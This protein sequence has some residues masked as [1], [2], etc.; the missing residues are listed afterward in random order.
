MQPAQPD[1][2]SADVQ[3]AVIYPWGIRVQRAVQPLARAAA[4][5]QGLGQGLGLA[6]KSAWVATSHSLFLPFD[7]LA[8][9]EYNVHHGL[10]DK[11]VAVANIVEVNDARL[12]T[13]PGAQAV[14]FDASALLHKHRGAPWLVSGGF[15]LGGQE[16]L[17]CEAVWGLIVC[18]AELGT[19]GR[20][21]PPM[22]ATAHAV[23]QWL[24]GHEAS[25]HSSPACGHIAALMDV[26]HTGLR[27]RATHLQACPSV[28]AQGRGHLV[29][30]LAGE[31][32]FP[33]AG[34]WRVASSAPTSTSTP[35]LACAAG[36][37]P[38]APSL[39]VFQ[40]R[41][42]RLWQVAAGLG[43][44]MSPAPSGADE[45]AQPSHF[46][47]LEFVQNTGLQQIRFPHPRLESLVMNSR[48]EYGR[49][50]FA[51]RATLGWDD[52]V[53]MHPPAGAH[54]QGFGTPSSSTG[55]IPLG[56]KDKFSL[57]VD[58]WHFKKTWGLN[59]H[60]RAALLRW[61]PASLSACPVEGRVDFGF[62]NSTWTSQQ[63]PL[64]FELQSGDAR[65]LVLTAEGLCAGTSV[66][67][68]L[69]GPAWHWGEAY[70]DVQDLV[71]QLLE[72]LPSHRRMGIDAADGPLRLHDTFAMPVVH[73]GFG[74]ARH[75]QASLGS[76]RAR[77][78]QHDGFGISLGAPADPMSW[79]LPPYV[80]TASMG[81]GI[82][83]G[84]DRDEDAGEGVDT[85]SGLRIGLPLRLSLESPGWAGAH[86]AADVGS[87]DV[88]TQIQSNTG[89]NTNTTVP[90]Q[91][92]VRGPSSAQLLGG[93][94]N[95]SMTI[96]AAATLL[97]NV[98]DAQHVSLV[99]HLGVGLHL[100]V[101][102]LVDIDF[103]T[104]WAWATRLA[105][106]P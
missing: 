27:L 79:V 18:D 11:L 66:A 95:T 64:R 46:R 10:V 88:I 55:H 38:W 58:G 77:D 45:H 69:T 21:R 97:P 17:L 41:G 98:P 43:A 65:L 33:N 89:T 3:H 70:K 36:A 99:A 101:A 34:A 12:A 25:L 24:E 87:A 5:P 8:T 9:S 78:P 106:G 105:R 23:A 68:H 20:V 19:T 52:F 86:L 81:L 4:P 102:W 16:A 56:P 13:L 100:A 73:S 60:H 94:V 85:P 47:T 6:L 93:L 28:D 30:A 2:R 62:D 92:H 104:D 51:P 54:E 49:L 82:A 59:N 29:L 22:H 35:G 50:R 80:G 40:P 76:R 71:P 90:W 91:V 44:L 37:D 31:P 14:R 26:G 42:E 74:T 75:V 83:V 72:G 61:G 63:G 67:P 96:E 84:V 57:S 7:G 103:D 53:V 39:R 1:P 15:A 48:G 32:V